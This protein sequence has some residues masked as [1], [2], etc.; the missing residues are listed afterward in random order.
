MIK[1][2]PPAAVFG[3]LVLALGTAYYLTRHD[4]DLLLTANKHSSKQCIDVRYAADKCAFVRRHCQDE[5][6]GMLNYLDLYYCG[7]NNSQPSQASAFA[8]VTSMCAFLFFLFLTIGMAASDFLLPNLSAIVKILRLSPSLAGAT[9]LAFGNGSSDVFSTYA[10]MNIGSG[11]L[12]IGELIGAASFITAVV[13]GV[14]VLFQP[15]KFTN[16]KDFLLNVTFFTV[17]ISFAIYFISD[18]ILQAWEC[19]VMLL[20]YVVYV[21]CHW[22]FSEENDIKALDV[23]AHPQ[24]VHHGS[25]PEAFPY[26]KPVAYDKAALAEN[27]APRPPP[28]KLRVSTSYTDTPIEDFVKSTPPRP[29]PEGASAPSQNK[30][31]IPSFEITRV[32]TNDPEP[33]AAPESSTFLTPTTTTSPPRP[34]VAQKSQSFSDIRQAEETDQAIAG[35]GQPPRRVSYP[36]AATDNSTGQGRRDEDFYGFSSRVRQSR[37]NSISPGGSESGADSLCAD[38]IPA[39]SR[40]P[41]PTIPFRPSLFGA[42]ETLV[43]LEDDKRTR[44]AA[45]SLSGGSSPMVPSPLGLEPVSP[46]SSPSP[47]TQTHYGSTAVQPQSSWDQQTTD[48]LSPSPQ[49]ETSPLIPTTSIGDVSTPFTNPFWD[50]ELGRVVQTLFPSVCDC[51]KSGHGGGS[52]TESL[53]TQIAKWTIGVL[54]A[55]PYLLLTVTVPTVNPENLSDHDDDESDA[56]VPA[57]KWLLLLQAVFGPFFVYFSLNV[58]KTGDVDGYKSPLYFSLATSA[59]CVLLVALTP[60]H[61]RTGRGPHYLRFL[62]LVGFVVSIAWIAFV[63]NEVVS[64]LKAL[65]VILHISDA[66]LGLTVLALGNSLGDCVSNIFIAQ[67]SEHVMMAVAACFGGPLLNVLVGIGFSGLVVMHHKHD[68]S[69]YRFELSNTLFISSAT[70]MLTVL[71][72]SVAIPLNN[73]VFSKPLGVTTISIWAVSTALNVYLETTSH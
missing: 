1:R 15:V 28:P 37:F 2:P 7:S 20:I 39:R 51:L 52:T 44:K 61:T 57:L 13:A 6:M 72:L 40:A 32:K 63:A 58:D 3:C 71:F 69:G 31:L 42:L 34:H 21:L 62:S 43:V 46:G 16:R 26:T 70:L 60:I 45:A 23:I 12:A 41:S 38:S 17:A 14:M 54:V 22:K 56:S 64:I 24:D 25:D 48:Y 50:K 49:T 27:A 30:T 55:G 53:W 73:W 68:Y 35:F 47:Q 36:S 19:A 29:Y 10:A 67:N 4:N 11:S 8:L 5:A 59:T 65:G 18:G 66:V 33:A 9:F